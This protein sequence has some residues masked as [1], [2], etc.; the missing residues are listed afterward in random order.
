MTDIKCYIRN[1][2]DL[3]S[4][5]MCEVETLLVSGQ[6]F[7]VLHEKY[8]FITKTTDKSMKWIICFSPV[9]LKVLF[10]RKAV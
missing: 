6:I 8:F 2:R 4:I 10:D 1:M 3:L 7:K 9:L 5:I